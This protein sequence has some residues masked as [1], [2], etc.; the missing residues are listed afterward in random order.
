MPKSSR[1]GYTRRQSQWIALA[2][3]FLVIGINLVRVHLFPDPRV[4]SQ[5]SKQYWAQVPIST[6]RGGIFDR[7]GIPLALSVPAESFFIDPLY[8]NPSNAV[9]LRGLLDQKE[10]LR[11]QKP[12]QGRF[13]WVRRKVDQSLAQTYLAR[14]IPGLFSI[15]ESARVYPHGHLGAHV[16]GF[17]DLDDN[18][19]AGIER[20]WNNVLFSPQQTRLLARDAKGKLLDIVGNS[21][22]ENYVGAGNIYL[23][24]DSRIQQ[25]LEENLTVGVQE[26]S[27]AWG[28]AVCLNPNDG[29]ILGLASYPTFNPNDRGSFSN[30]EAL[31]NN[32]VARVYEPGSTFKPLVMGLAMEEG[33]VSGSDRFSCSGSVRIADHIIRDVKKGGHGVEDPK[34][35]LVNSC[36]VGM[37]LI[38]VRF[39]V[40][41]FYQGL[42]SLG[43]GQRTGIDLA[44]EEAGLMQP[45]ERW[46]GVVPANVAI[47]QGVG[48]TPIQLVSAIAAIA[49]GGHL[50][51]PYVVREVRDDK[52]NVIYRGKRTP[53]SAVFSPGIASYLRDSMRE[54]VKT[55][56]GKEA[57]TPLEEVAGKTGTA[58]VASG[59]T[60][61]KGR[62]VASFVG[63][64]PY[65]K[66]RYVLL[67]VIGEPKGGRF[68]GGELAA[69]VFKN[70]VEAISL[71]PRV[72][73]D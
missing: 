65:K 2:A 30:Q 15:R 33:L 20:A 69:P 37:A 62:Y 43:F 23:S 53:K 16:L 52:G 10:L 9:M 46:L 3:A 70:I 34:K 7:N 72:G 55:G 24:I 4:S 66:P 63:F 57:D 54:V 45:P 61:T 56:T 1:S 73:K 6:S 59:G 64:W 5:A 71:L 8:W 27:A 35:I 58:Q 11:F 50:L 31:R 41:R 51:K 40:F 28:A 12:L 19:L 13:V 17:C 42:R 14:D 67:V 29:S 44:G 47:G 36:N 39:H 18:G 38:G 60:Y 22:D 49:N 32:V 21:S 68:Y 25:I 48:V 26:A